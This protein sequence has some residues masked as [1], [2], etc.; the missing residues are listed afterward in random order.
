MTSTVHPASPVPQDHLPEGG[1]SMSV[2]P[3]I[4]LDPVIH[5]FCVVEIAAL[6]VTYQPG[7]IPEPVSN[8]CGHRW[9]RELGRFDV[10]LVCTLPAA[11]RGCPHD[12]L[13]GDGVS[14]GTV[15]DEW[16]AA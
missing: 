8:N 3:P 6:A 5:A 14:H 15:M 7:D 9:Q 10:D 4:W 2:E 13:D 11:H 12:A 1:N 16:M